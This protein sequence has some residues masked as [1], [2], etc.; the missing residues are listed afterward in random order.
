VRKRFAHEALAVQNGHMR[1]YKIQTEYQLADI[2]TKGLQLAQ[3]E[4]CLYSLLGE[5]PTAGGKE[6]LRDLGLGR[7]RDRL[8]S[9]VDLEVKVTSTLRRGV[10]P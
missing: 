6:G 8:G 7:G 5:N 4:R 9:R 10:W 2:L 3:F 1:L